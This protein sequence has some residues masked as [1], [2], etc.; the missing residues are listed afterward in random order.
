MNKLSKYITACVFGITAASTAFAQN[1]QDAIMMG[2]NNL[3]IAAGYGY[4]SWDHYWEGT[5]KRDNQNIGTFSSRSVTAMLNY[6]LTKDINLMVS[7]PYVST[8]TSGGTLAGMNGI[9]DLSFYV[10][11][12][13]LRKISGSNKLSV[14]AVAGY[15]APSHNYN[16]DLMPMSIGMGSNAASG[17][18]IADYQLSK[19]FVTLSGSYLYRNNVNIDRP[20]YYTTRQINS[21]EVQMPNV[22]S[23]QVRTGYRT[24]MI[25]AEAFFDQSKTFGGFDIRKNDM[26]FVSN[27]VNMTNIGFEGKY[28]LKALPELGI[29]AMAWRTLSGRNTGQATG[30][31]AGILYNLKIANHPLSRD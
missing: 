15:I 17:R 7:V 4:S 28:Y 1:E 2:K 10:K 31:M 12:R 11:Y 25:I 23:Y 13:P 26:P 8:K 22:G 5:F 14:F 21:H 30:F 18:L 27:E 9:Q 3:C 16:I 19:I 24:H 6:G 29:H 20:S